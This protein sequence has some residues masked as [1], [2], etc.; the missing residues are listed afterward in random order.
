[1]LFFY[2]PK[3]ALATRLRPTDPNGLRRR[4]ILCSRSEEKKQQAELDDE[5][6]ELLLLLRGFCARRR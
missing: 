4:R 3:T 2:D 6:A 1:M 5:Q